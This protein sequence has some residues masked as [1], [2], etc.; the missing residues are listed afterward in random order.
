MQKKR[1]YTTEEDA[2]VKG[3]VGYTVVYEEPKEEENPP[4]Q[5]QE[6]DILKVIQP[7]QIPA[8]KVA[9]TV[10]PIHKE[11]H[12]VWFIAGVV[13]AIV[14]LYLF[15]TSKAYLLIGLGL[16]CYA[17]AA[18]MYIKHLRRK[19]VDEMQTQV[20]HLTIDHPIRTGFE[21]ALGVGLFGLICLIIGT[22]LVVLFAGAIFMWLWDKLLGLIPAGLF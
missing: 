7:G 21:F 16:C 20:V 9:R 17:Y 10:H 8:P 13:G 12:S 4:E 19:Y 14:V 11:D 2:V 18:Y 1:G 6:L 5:N 3:K 15:F 22:I